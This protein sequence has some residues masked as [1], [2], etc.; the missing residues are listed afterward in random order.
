MTAPKEPD[1]P[2]LA[3]INKEHPR[4]WRVEEDWTAEIQ[5]ANG[6][7]ILKI[8]YPKRLWLARL[9]VDAVNAYGQ[10]ASVALP[11]E[12][13]Q[14]VSDLRAMAQWFESD[15]MFQERDEAL[16]VADLLERLAQ[17]HTED[18]KCE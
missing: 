4:P 15:A 6:V 17:Q 3:A 7:V 2:W 13:A 1:F 8:E 11:E 16:R 18:E 5:D 12:V 9:I 10:P 14:S